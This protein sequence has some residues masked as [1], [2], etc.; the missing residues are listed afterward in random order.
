VVPGASLRDG[1]TA[2][3]PLEIAERL[4]R[5]FSFAGD[6]V[7]DPFAGSGTTA[8]AATRVGRNSISV[9]VE[10]QYLN[11]ATRRAAGEASR[12]SMGCCAATIVEMQV[13]SREE[14]SDL[15]VPLSIE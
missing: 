15:R 3:F 12:S 7:L 2:P 1:H 10:E 14:G 8:V 9:E 4:I 6:T 5:L 11:A 13:R